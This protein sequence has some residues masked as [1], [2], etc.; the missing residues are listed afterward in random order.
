MSNRDQMI[1]AIETHC[2]AIAND[3]KAGWLQ[4]LAEDVVIEDPVGV[5]T[6]RGIDTVSTA[7][8]AEI[9]AI[10]PVR[11]W[12]MEDVIVCG[13][14]AIAILAAEVGPGEPSRRVAPIVDHFTFNAAGKVATM[15]AFFEF[16]NSP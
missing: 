6:Y 11:L 2:R 15:R 5:A 13:N 12:L 1:K 10:R 7:F 16:D 4:I 14:E 9:D 3:D 8:W